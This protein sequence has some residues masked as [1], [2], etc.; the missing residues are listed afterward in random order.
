MK[1]HCFSR[2]LTGGLRAIACCV[3]ILLLLLNL[4]YLSEVSYALEN[5]EQVTIRGCVLESILMVA[6]A[7]VVLFAGSFLRL[8]A[9]LKEKTFFGVLTLLYTLMALYLILNSDST[10]RADAN[11]FYSSARE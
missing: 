6:A 10:L 11:S 5:F 1:N 4:V 8:P 7:G 3:C 2:F 9:R